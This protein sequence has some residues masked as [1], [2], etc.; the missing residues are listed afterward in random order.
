MNSTSLIS[1][2]HGASPVVCT[3]AEMVVEAD[4]SRPRNSS[5]QPAASSS[6]SEAYGLSR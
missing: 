6:C 2:A 3:E 1:C 4:I 5:A